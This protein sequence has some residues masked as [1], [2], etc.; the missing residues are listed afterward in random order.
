[1]L[2]QHQ[3]DYTEARRLYG[4]SLKIAEELGDKQGIANTL[5][6]LGMLAQDAGGLY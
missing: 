4:E 1:M 2:A 6:Q 3:G 5:H